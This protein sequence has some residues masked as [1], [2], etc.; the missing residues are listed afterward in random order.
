MYKIYRRATSDSN[1]LTLIAEIDPINCSFDD[2]LSTY[3][4]T[5]QIELHDASTATT[6]VVWQRPV[7]PQ[8]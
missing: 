8:E 1:E 4:E 5:D 7:P 2:L 6:S 3:P